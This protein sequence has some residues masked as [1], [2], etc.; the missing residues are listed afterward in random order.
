M[1]LGV[2]LALMIPSFETTLIPSKGTASNDVELSTRPHL[3]HHNTEDQAFEGRNHVQTVASMQIYGPYVTEV[4][5]LEAM[6][7]CVNIISLFLRPDLQRA[8]VFLISGLSPIIGWRIRVQLCLLSL[9]P[10]FII[11]L[12]LEKEFR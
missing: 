1:A 12:E 2:E 8:S 6:P 11:L 9:C 4:L 5:G 10:L 7:H 3:L